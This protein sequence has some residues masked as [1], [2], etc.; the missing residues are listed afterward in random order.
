M[1]LATA[2]GVQSAT[3]TVNYVGGTYD[4]F[5]QDISDMV[6]GYNGAGGSTSPG[7]SIAVAMPYYNNVTAG[8][9]SRNAYLYGYNFALDPT[10]TVASISLDNNRQMSLFAFDLVSL[11]PQVNLGSVVDATT[12]NGR[13][14]PVNNIGIS[15]DNNYQ[16][17]GIGINNSGNTLSDSVWPARRTGPRGKSTSGTDRRSTSARRRSTMSSRSAARPSTW[18]RASTRT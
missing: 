16:L 7:E 6:N 9:Q 13:S 4:T 10:K 1:I 2:V 5:N 11:P 15:E 17:T 14:I 3:I 8:K 12:G 18:R